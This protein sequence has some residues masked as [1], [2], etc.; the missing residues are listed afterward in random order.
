MVKEEKQRLKQRD[1]IPPVILKRPANHGLEEDP[2]I[3]IRNRRMFSSLLSTLE[4]FREEND[5]VEKSEKWK[6][7]EEISRRALQR[8]AEESQRLREKQK[9]EWEERRYIPQKC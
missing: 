2:K 5:T 9:K 1:F 4:K 3:K 6:K 8:T 7:R